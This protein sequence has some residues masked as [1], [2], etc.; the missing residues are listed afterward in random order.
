MKL[1]ALTVLLAVAGAATGAH[2]AEYVAVA[3]D[4]ATGTFGFVS[5][6]PS[7]Q[8]AE[9]AATAECAKDSDNCEGIAVFDHGCVSLAR[10]ADD[11]T[12]GLY[13]SKSRAGAQQ[14]AVKECSESGGSGCN[15]HDTYCA[16]TDLDM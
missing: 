14:G 1:T 13:L 5:G 6:A 3:G 4:K 12:Y 11:K 8:D 7:K 10:S 2:A 16:P 15:V 9:E